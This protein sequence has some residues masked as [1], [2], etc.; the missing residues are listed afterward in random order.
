[1]PI[2][3]SGVLFEQAARKLGYHPFP[4]PMAILSQS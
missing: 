2:K 3:S 4:A 1:M